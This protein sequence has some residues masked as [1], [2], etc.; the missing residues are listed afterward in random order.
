M[1]DN[2]VICQDLALVK[3]NKKR[4]PPRIINEYIYSQ[5][6]YSFFILE[7]HEGTNEYI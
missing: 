6:M 7:E 2:S 5:L 3:K 1:G 4:Y